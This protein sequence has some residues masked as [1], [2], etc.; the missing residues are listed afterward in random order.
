MAKF[1]K[2]EATA[3]KRRVALYVYLSDGVTPA[4]LATNWAAVA[5]S[6]AL[7]GT[8]HATVQATTPGVGGNVLTIKLKNDGAGAGNL[9]NSGN[10][11]TFHYA[12]GV[13]TMANL[14]TA[15]TASGVLTLAGYT[16]TD[17]LTNPGDT[18]G[19]LALVLGQ[20][21]GFRV[22]AGAFAYA[23]SAGT[24][25]NT[26]VDGEWVYE[27]TQAELNFTG[28]EFGVKV[29][30]PDQQAVVQ[31]VGTQAGRLRVLAPGSLGNGYT[32]TTAADGAGAG[33]MTNVGNAYTF[34][35]A[36]GVTTM[37]NLATALAATGLFE[38]VAGSFTGANTLVSAGDTQGPLA[39]AGGFDGFL[40]RIVTCEM[41]D[42]ADFASIGEGANTYGDML[43]GI[44]SGV[45]CKVADFRTGTY[46]FRDAA[47][48][49]NRWTVIADASGRISI[50]AG[51]LT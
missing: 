36:T 48:T 23:D 11:Y 8:H 50:V 33:S 42:A 15:L 27:A 20:D 12:T 45:L 29:D 40:R 30:R 39:F 5:A 25:T 43:R 7:I 34:H 32:F 44:F 35:Y 19:P 9:T 28:S 16:G 24:N 6:V 14:A 17:V 3:A 21:I 31:L 46:V 51:D 18:Q 41:N 13:T 26:G 49:K 22:R 1:R 47:D 10:D 37:T 2:N 38:L 4:P